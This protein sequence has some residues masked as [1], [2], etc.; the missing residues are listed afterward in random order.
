M[1]LSVWVVREHKLQGRVKDLEQD[2]KNQLKKAISR[3]LRAQFILPGPDGESD[4]DDGDCQ[5]E[6]GDDYLYGDSS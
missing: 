1:S 4:W 6:P 2:A 3:G 5:S